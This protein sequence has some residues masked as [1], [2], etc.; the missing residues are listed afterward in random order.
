MDDLGHKKRLAC[1]TT[2]RADYSHLRWPMREL[3]DQTNWDVKLIATGAHL[4]PQFGYSIDEILKDGFEVDHRVPCLL[5]SDDEQSIATTIGLATIG[6]AQVFAEMKPD[7]VFLIA[8]RY[9]LMAP[10]TAAM[11][12][13]IPIVHLEGGEVSEGAIDDSVRNAITKLAHIHLTPHEQA[14]ERVLAMGEEPWR[15]HVVG[16]PSID[17]LKRSKLLD[18]NLLEEELKIEL[19]PEPLL[20]AYHPVT[21]DSDPIAESNALFAALESLSEPVFFC[22]P[23][24]DHHYHQLVTKAQQFVKRH[25]KSQLFVNLNPHIYWSLLAQ[26]RALV[27]NSSSGIMEAA[28]LGLPVVNIGRRQQG[29]LKAMNVIDVVG[30]ASAIKQAIEKALGP[31]FASSIKDMSNPYGDGQAAQ[32]IAQIIGDL[33]TRARLLDKRALNPPS[34]PWQSP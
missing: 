3:I 13:R 20:V 19:N 9:E 30:E 16:A 17:H 1:V 10:A 6:F 7:A 29:R 33:P 21:L 2:S 28:S 31:E 8:D 25:P 18:R 12:M 26:V 23:N 24:A 5:A 27:G 14:K 15:V 34:E 32:R 11:A 22:F 4:A